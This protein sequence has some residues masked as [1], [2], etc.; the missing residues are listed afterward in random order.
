LGRP[1]Q[2]SFEASLLTY[3]GD[4]DDDDDDDNFIKLLLEV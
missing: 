1:K 3:D 2:V 4:D